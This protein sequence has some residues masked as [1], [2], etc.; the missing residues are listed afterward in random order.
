MPLAHFRNIETNLITSTPTN[1]GKCEIC[2]QDGTLYTKNSINHI[3][4]EEHRNEFYKKI[5]RKAKLDKLNYE[6][7]RSSEQNQ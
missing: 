6:K 5:T 3:F 4:C 1:I 2:G 7:R